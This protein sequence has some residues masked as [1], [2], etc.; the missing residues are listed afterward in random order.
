M[1]PP[2]NFFCFDYKN[3]ILQWFDFFSAETFKKISS[4]K[5]LAESE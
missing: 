3:A 5:G 4:T 1:A 2:E